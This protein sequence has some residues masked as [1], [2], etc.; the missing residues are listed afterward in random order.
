MKTFHKL[1]YIFFILSIIAFG[2]TIPIYSDEFVYKYISSRFFLDQFEAITHLPQCQGS[3]TMDQPWFFA[4]HR[5]LSSLVYWDFA[6]SWPLRLLGIFSCVLW[7]MTAKKIVFKNNASLLPLFSL[8]LLPLLMVLNRP[9]QS[10]LW[11]ALL[12]FCLTSLRQDYSVL[13]QGL[14]IIGLFIIYSF[15]LPVHGASLF[16]LTVALL[17]SWN[18]V[19]HKALKSVGII[20]TG[21]QWISAFLYYGTPCTEAPFLS[22]LFSSLTL[23]PSDLLSMNVKEIIWRGKMAIF[24][25]TLIPHFIFAGNYQGKWLPIVFDMSLVESIINGFIWV[26]FYLSSLA[27]LLYSIFSLFVFIKKRDLASFHARFLSLAITYYGLT[28]FITWHS[29]YRASLE[30]PL[31]FMLFSMVLMDIEKRYPWVK[32]GGGFISLMCLLSYG[33]LVVHF[34]SHFKENQTMVFSDYYRK[35]VRDELHKTREQCSL[36]ISKEPRVLVDREVLRLAWREL[37]FPIY[38]PYITNY[39]GQ[40]I[41]DLELFLKKLRATGYLLRCDQLPDSLISYPSETSGIYCCSR[42]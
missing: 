5:L 38:A 23:A 30:I 11:M 15:M 32:A 27:V 2:L 40:D 18:L 41:E 6:S 26:V 16:F 36:D 9:E 14:F 33:N 34:I 25:D 28:F 12:P 8:G 22:Q 21:Y 24:P 7:I 17:M 1:Y 35:E 20:L 42:F 39:W 3:L 10:L 19:T 31:L 29:F 37:D 13:T 4:I